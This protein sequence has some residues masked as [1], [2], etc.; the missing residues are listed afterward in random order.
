MGMRKQRWTSVCKI[1]CFLAMC[2]VTLFCLSY[3]FRPVS[4]SRKNI[5]GFYAEQK[6]T[7]D[8][9]YIG[10]S[11]C[12]RYWEGLQA[13]NDYGFTSFNIAADAIQPQVLK[14]LVK[15]AQKT[16]S[17]QLF[18]VDLRPFQYGDL[19]SQQEELLNMERVAP[20]RNVSD[21][22][23]YSLNRY[24]MVENGAPSGEE[25][26]T[27]HFDL[28]KYHS[29][30]VSLLQ[31]DNWRYLDNEEPLDNKGFW[32]NDEVSSI[33]RADFSAVTEMQ[34]LS[35]EVDGIFRDLLT[36]CKENHLEVLFVVHAYQIAEEDQKKYNY[37]KQV[38]EEEYGF[39]YL[40][41]NDYFE[42]IGFDPDHDFYNMDH[43]NL[44]GAD[45]YT[46]FLAGYIHR[47]YQLPDHRKDDSYESWNE[48][49]IKWSREMD[50]VR[51]RMLQ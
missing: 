13:W 6:N 2:L 4:V 39:D 20:F 41:V 25:K 23:K 21:S 1:V 31:K 10:G 51:E 26:W 24:Q 48:C 50:A 40:N 35:E 38:I 18:V 34:P 3:L 27:Y 22:M 8:M 15:E 17:P 44:L 36:Y 49:F 33:L 16:Q 46:N 5:C 9:V 11:A 43:A 30:V 42:E 12:Y 37:M 28:A 14:Y 29:L 32:E 7:L 19:Y 47:T 45:K